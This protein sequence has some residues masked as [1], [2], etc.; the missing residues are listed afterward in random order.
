MKNLISVLSILISISSYSQNAK[1]DFLKD[2]DFIYENLKETSSHK[3]QKDRQKAVDV[4]YKELLKQNI[5][6]STLESFVKLY[7]LLDEVHDYHN[8]NL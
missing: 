4:K 1:T 3:T 7:E 5:Q 6:L 2:L 8:E